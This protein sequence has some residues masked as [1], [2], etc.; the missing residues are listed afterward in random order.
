MLYIFKGDSQYHDMLQSSNINFLYNKHRVYFVIR[1]LY[2][3]GKLIDLAIPLHANITSITQL[4]GWFLECIVTDHTKPGNKAGFNLA[5]AIPYS[6]SEFFNINKL[7]QNLKL[8][9]EI[10]T[11]NI[12]FLKQTLQKMLDNYA[13]G[14]R[15]T[16]GI[17]FDRALEILA[18]C[19]TLR[20]TLK[21]QKVKTNTISK[22][23]A[24]NKTPQQANVNTIQP[25][26]IT[27]KQNTDNNTILRDFQNSSNKVDVAK[28]F[29]ELHP[30]YIESIKKNVGGNV[31]KSKDHGNIKDDTNKK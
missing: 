11:I 9:D 5:K 4:E 3:K 10:A 27:T 22:Q 30:E 20:Q 8:S 31:G 1:G 15:P 28:K 26:I 21:Q 29:K 14:I 19:V 17:D 13:N 18:E 7:S 25:N 6:K 2:Y 24:S 12:K 16:H 23:Q